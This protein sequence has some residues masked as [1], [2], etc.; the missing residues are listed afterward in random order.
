MKFK[1]KRDLFFMFFLIGLSRSVS[2]QSNP[3]YVITDKGDTI[4]CSIKQELFGGLKY[5]PVSDE[6]AKRIVAERIKE[7]YHNKEKNPFL[8]KKLPKPSAI[9]FVERLEFG[10]I[11]L[12]EL[13]QS[14][15]GGIQ[16]GRMTP[17]STRR[18]WY[19][20]KNGEHK[21]FLIKTN[22]L[23]SLGTSRKDRKAAFDELLGDDQ[24]LL[25][26]FKNKEEYSFDEIRETI[27]AYNTK[28]VKV[29]VSSEFNR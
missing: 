27:K 5:T 22:Q 4:L 25:Q 20:E 9:K 8:A 26:Q 19:A 29:G 12:Y 13:Y 17:G 18:F 11:C 24:E 6:Q 3:E 21:L 7:Y 14:S 2:A 15:P 23:V 1:L 16:Q 28:H 10:Q